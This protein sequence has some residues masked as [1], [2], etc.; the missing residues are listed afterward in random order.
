M[1]LIERIRKNR[2]KR[3]RIIHI[4]AGIIILLHAF[5]RYTEGHANYG[6]FAVAGTLFLTVAILHHSLSLHAP[7]VDGVF[8]LI[9][10]SLSFAIC[11]EYIHA[12]KKAIP[13]CYAIMG[14][15]Q[16]FMAFYHGHKGIRK[17]RTRNTASATSHTDIEMNSADS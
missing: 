8:F 17:H 15:A 7:W 4:L 6:Y 9:E 16:V 11:M 10:A 2:E 5:G 13:V 14:C 12:G 1:K 3:M